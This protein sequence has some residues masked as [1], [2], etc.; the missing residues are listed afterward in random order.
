MAIHAEKK[1]MCLVV[2]T[3]ADHPMD[4]LSGAHNHA[5]PLGKFVGGCLT[6]LT[7]P[8]NNSLMSL[9]FGN[10]GFFDGYITCSR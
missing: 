7:F 6:S 1:E 8:S 4:Q 5:L 9:K 3:S 10:L 2:G